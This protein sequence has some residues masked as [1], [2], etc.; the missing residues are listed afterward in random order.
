MWNF[1]FK[2][3]VE[4]FR[5]LKLKIIVKFLLSKVAECCKF[6]TNEYFKKLDPYYY[7]KTAHCS[8][9]N[10]MNMKIAPEGSF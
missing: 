4:V 3:N 6:T 2:K 10:K 8:S 5:I 1:K 9:E 7:L